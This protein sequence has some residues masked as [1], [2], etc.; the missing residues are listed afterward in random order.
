MNGRDL[1]ELSSYGIARLRQIIFNA[2]QSLSRDSALCHEKAFQEDFNTNIGETLTACLIPHDYEFESD[3]TTR[4]DRIWHRIEQYIKANNDRCLKVGEI[5]NEAGIS[6]STLL[7]IFKFRFG[8][9]PKTYLNTHRLHAVRR[10]LKN[11]DS[12]KQKVS[13]V[14]NNLGFWHMGQFAMDYRRLFGELPSQ[15]LTKL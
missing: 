8:V 5:C 10:I 7:R 4:S 13:D 3:R 12:K 6:E 14:A 1:I 2:V 11:S 15:T 9:S